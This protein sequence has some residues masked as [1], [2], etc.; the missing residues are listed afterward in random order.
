MAQ[1]NCDKQQERISLIMHGIENQRRNERSSPGLLVAAREIYR[2][3]R[4]QDLSRRY[5]ET[6]KSLVNEYPAVQTW[7]RENQEMFAPIRQW[8]FPESSRHHQ[9]DFDHRNH[10]ILSNESDM[11]SDEDE[12][13]GY[14]DAG[15]I[16]DEYD[17]LAVTVTGAGAEEVNGLYQE[18]GSCDG[19]PKFLRR[20]ADRSGRVMSYYVFRCKLSS[21]ER[22][23][24]ISYVPDGLRPGT[25][26]DVDFYSV[27][28]A[29]SDWS[30]AVPPTAGW[31][32][33]HRQGPNTARF[34]PPPTLELHTRGETPTLHHGEDDDMDTWDQ[35][36][37]MDETQGVGI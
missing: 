6:I 26:K 24:Y 9:R 11:N 7:V 34:H 8:I 19:V 28:P 18:Q 32:I 2:T 22:R 5:Y 36:E 17:I 37:S 1:L 27:S 10:N 30:G 29:A 35:D 25:T 16:H 13:S 31:S 3:G 4:H 20:T 23:F 15:N 21:G 33:C 14:G 12:D